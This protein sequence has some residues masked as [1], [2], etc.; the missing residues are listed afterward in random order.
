MRESIGTIVSAAAALLLAV[1]V[2]NIY[3]LNGE[4]GGD[5]STLKRERIAT[6]YVLPLTDLLLDVERYRNSI[7]IL[8]NPPAEPGLRGRIDREL[9]ALRSRSRG[10]ASLKIS[11]DLRALDS[12]WARARR[13]RYPTGDAN[14]RSVVGAI[15][16]LFAQ[17]EAT[18][19]IEYDPNQDVQNVGDATFAK[20]PD[21][22]NEIYHS[23]LVAENAIAHLG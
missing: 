14:E 19:G 9:A 21:A 20:I 18:S 7:A 15:E 17:I 6:A 23:D 2:A 11:A 4:A 10:A 3:H 16:N 1:M 13:D 12:S 8:K 22:I 5:L